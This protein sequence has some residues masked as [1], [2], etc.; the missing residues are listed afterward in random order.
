MVHSGSEVSSVLMICRALST[1]VRARDKGLTTGQT[2]A[3]PHAEV[4]ASALQD[5][6]RPQGLR[7]K[8]P[9]AAGAVCRKGTVD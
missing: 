9:V 1:H 5:N 3:V 4:R 8:G 2:S 6:G 7:A